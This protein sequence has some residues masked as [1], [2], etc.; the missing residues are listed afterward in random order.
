M[1]DGRTHEYVVRLRA[2]TSAD[3]MTAGFYCLA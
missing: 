2:V 3:G 1:D